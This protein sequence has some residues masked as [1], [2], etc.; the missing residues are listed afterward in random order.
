MTSELGISLLSSEKEKAVI[1]TAL[2][3]IT[4]QA[5]RVSVRAYI[6]SEGIQMSKSLTRAIYNVPTSSLMLTTEAVT[7]IIQHF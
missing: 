4:T 3:M 2:L 6:Y 1:L 5:I 7:S